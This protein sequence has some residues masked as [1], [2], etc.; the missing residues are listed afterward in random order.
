MK[1][2]LPVDGSPY[3]KRMLGYVAAHDEITYRRASA[4]DDLILDLGATLVEMTPDEHD[5]GVAL[6]SHVPQVV[7]SIMARRFIEAPNAALGLAGQGVRDVTRIAASD[8]DLWVQ[9]LG[10]NASPVRYCRKPAPCRV[11]S[12]IRSFT[13]AETRRPE[14]VSSA[15]SAS[16]D[17]ASRP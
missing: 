4:I 9:I 3:T 5:R 14:R 10:A 2:L 15:S 13:P 1:I 6:I 7:S 12:V 17:I 16:T 11:T 8:P